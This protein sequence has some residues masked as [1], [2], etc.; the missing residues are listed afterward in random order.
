MLELVQAEIA[1]EARAGPGRLYA[2]ARHRCGRGAQSLVPCLAGHPRSAARGKNTTRARARLLDGTR[3]ACKSRQAG[4][5]ARR[6]PLSEG[7][8]AEHGPDLGELDPGSYSGSGCV[9]GL[10]LVVA[11]EAEVAVEEFG[12]EFRIG[13]GSSC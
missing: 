12:L 2:R 6:C 5:W 1:R 13:P 9:E 4:A 3:R 7:E 11:V 8:A 10:G